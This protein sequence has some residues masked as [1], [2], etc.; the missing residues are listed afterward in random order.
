MLIANSQPL[1]AQAAKPKK[2]ARGVARAAPRVSS[3]MWEG[4]S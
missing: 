4:P 3:L 1:T 2:T